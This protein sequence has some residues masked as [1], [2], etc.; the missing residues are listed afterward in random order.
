MLPDNYSGSKF[1]ARKPSVTSSVRHHHRRR[2][3][4]QEKK[5]ETEREREKERKKN[6]NRFDSNRIVSLSPSLSLQNCVV[7]HNAATQK[8]K[9]G[10]KR[11]KKR[12][13]STRNARART[14]TQ[15]SSFSSSSKASHLKQVKAAKNLEFLLTKSFSKE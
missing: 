2:R 3:R 12:S 14:H 15:S 8:I 5:R 7:R 6:A 10:A 4:R 1:D 13:S 9:E 11:R